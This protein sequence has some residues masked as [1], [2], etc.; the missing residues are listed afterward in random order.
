MA[1]LPHDRES[2][3]STQL[4]SATV[5]D[6]AECGICQDVYKDPVELPCGHTFCRACISLWLSS[7]KTC[8]LDRVP[9]FEAEDE[10]DEEVELPSI[11]EL[12]EGANQQIS[13]VEANL[14]AVQRAIRI[15]RRLL[16]KSF[17]DIFMSQIKEAKSQAQYEKLCKA[18]QKYHEAL[19]ILRT[20]ER[21]RWS[22]FAS[23]FLAFAAEQLGREADS[24]D[25]SQ[26]PDVVVV[27]RAKTAQWQAAARDFT[28]M[29]QNCLRWGDVS[30]H[31][32][33]REL[34]ME[35]MIELMHLDEDAD[36]S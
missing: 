17:H 16:E 7:K 14:V 20:N 4:K 21:T 2:F 10:V 34:D 6:D 27:V 35:D 18:R 22:A 11:E 3:L 23:G 8:P 24:I 29:V 1:S 26:L 31:T 32:L 25:T 5:E 15:V 36:A 19:Q 9:L 12:I 13:T 33:L 30:V 28:W